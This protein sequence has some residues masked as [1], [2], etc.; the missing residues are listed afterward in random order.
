M[1][2]NGASAWLDLQAGVEVLQAV[3]GCGQ[4]EVRIGHRLLMEACLCQA[5]VPQELRQSAL[6]LLSTVAAC[7]PLSTTARPRLWP[8]IRCLTKSS[9]IG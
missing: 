2:G 3:P 5:E 4:Y 1:S 8:S 9:C 7:S 6:A